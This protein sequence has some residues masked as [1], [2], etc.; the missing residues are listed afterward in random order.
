MAPR[1]KIPITLSK[2]LSSFMEEGEGVDKK[3]NIPIRTDPYTD[4]NLLFIYS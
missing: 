3:W 1:T 4:L 2:N